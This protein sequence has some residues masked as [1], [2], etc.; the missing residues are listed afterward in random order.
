MSKINVDNQLVIEEPFIK[1][2][3]EQVKKCARQTQKFLE[4]DCNYIT[5]CLK[6]IENGVPTSESEREHALQQLESCLQRISGLKE[7]IMGYQKTESHLLAQSKSRIGTFLEL[8]NMHSTADLEYHGWCQARLDRILVDY[9]LRSGYHNTAEKL[10]PMRNVEAFSDAELFATCTKIENALLSL[11]RCSEA[12]QWCT[13]NRSAL[14]KLEIDLEFE[15]HLQEYIEL[16]RANL[17][18]EAIDYLKKNVRSWSSTHLEKIARASTLLVFPPNTT[19]APYKD[20][21]SFKRWEMLSQ[22]FRKAVYSLYGLPSQPLLVLLLQA[23]LAGLKTPDCCSTDAALSKRNCPV[24][25]IE[26]IGKMSENLPLNRHANSMLVCAISGKKMNEDNPPMRLPNGNVYSL[27]SLE[28]MNQTLN[29]VVC[30]RSGDEFS[31]ND[32]Q[33]LF[34]F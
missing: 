22:R 15:L 32:C 1:T 11:H 26:K 25:Q 34:I 13:E 18:T 16:V 24:C 14:R 20:M 9:M 2:P 21:F 31:I 8:N 33:K 19:C 4:K 28:D 7:K 12:L 29:K 3:L 10:I 23:G 27:R 30:P 5:Q 6:G 17:K